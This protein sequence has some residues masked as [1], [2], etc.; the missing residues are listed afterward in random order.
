MNCIEWI[1]YGVDLSEIKIPDN[2][3]TANQLFKWSN[4]NLEKFNYKFKNYE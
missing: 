4:I 1:V 3:L 2:I